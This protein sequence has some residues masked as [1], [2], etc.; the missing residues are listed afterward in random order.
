M[1]QQP[2]TFYKFFFSFA[3]VLKPS[4]WFDDMILLDKQATQWNGAMFYK[5][6]PSYTTRLRGDIIWEKQI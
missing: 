6:G 5:T 3:V 2:K 1:R 4:S